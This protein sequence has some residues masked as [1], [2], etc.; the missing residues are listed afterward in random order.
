MQGT[1]VPKTM[2]HALKPI[3]YQSEKHKKLT[4]LIN[5]INARSLWEAHVKQERRKATGVDGVTKD[6]YAKELPENLQ[7]L[8][9][10]MKRLDYIP[11]PVRR[12]YIPKANGKLRPLGIPA[13]EDKLVQSVMADI[14]NEVY[15][16]RFLSCSYG[17]RPERSAHDVVRGINQAVMTRH[18]NYVLEADIR[19]FF[20]NLDQ[21]WLIKFLEHDIA[22]RNFI[23]YIVRFLKAGV[24]EG[25]ELT[26]SDKGTPQG[27]LISPVLANVYL[28][29][30]LDLWI[31]KRVKR[32][33]IGEMF[34]FRYADDFV[35]LF[36]TEKEAR[37]VMGMLKERLEA[38]GLELAE[39]KT[40]ILPIGKYKGTKESFDFLGFTFFN[41][42]TK[43][44]HY[45]LGIRSSEK[46]MKAKRMAVREW[47]WTRLRKPIV[48]TLIKL[49]REL[50]GHYNYY[51]INGNARALCKFRWYVMR[52][53]VKMLRR[54]GQRRPITW[55]KFIELWSEYVAPVS[56]TRE[57][58]KCKPMSI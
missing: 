33:V 6:E 57:I 27:C 58:W 11:Q 14:L 38:F 39:D 50:A 5:R 49:N 46:K 16:P 56:I 1:R 22:D 45:R 54:R 23:R 9:E 13:Y 2:E 26:D 55:K 3:R 51:G 21:K 7:S 36:Q 24:M 17:F 29:Y 30:V 10:R 19:G 44:G 31:T 12:T 28:H 25:T 53:T 48:E 37:M 8:V 18:V 43:D 32:Q 20:D 34:Y 4:T 42:K 15:E 52:A 40:R 41:A 35:I 47:L